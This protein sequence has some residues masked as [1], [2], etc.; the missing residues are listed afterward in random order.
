MKTNVVKQAI[1]PEKDF[2]AYRPIR[3]QWRA[4]V[5]EVSIHWRQRFGF[6]CSAFRHLTRFVFVDIDP[7]STKGLN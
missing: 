7:S 2:Y 4:L 3:V 1:P 5:L 6:G